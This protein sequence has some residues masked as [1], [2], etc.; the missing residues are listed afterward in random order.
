MGLFSLPGSRS[1]SRKNNKKDQPDL[2]T[3][4]FEELLRISYKYLYD[5]QDIC[6]RDYQL[7]DYQRWFYDQETGELTFSD[8]GI[9]KLIIDYEEVGSLSLKS[10]T[11]LW[12]WGNPHLEEKIKSEIGVV[13]DYGERREFEKLTDAQ[14]TADEHDAWEMA[15]IASYLMQTKGV[16]RVPTEDKMLYSFM[17]FK[18]IRWPESGT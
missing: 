17:I 13:K 15:A 2:D 3:I 1:K 14:W 12:A 7:L 5:Q 16:Y 10:N 18:N 4:S 11:W 8:N 9:T 6:K